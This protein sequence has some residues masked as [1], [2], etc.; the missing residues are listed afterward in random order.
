MPILRFFGGV[1]VIFYFTLAY[2]QAHAQSPPLQRQTST[3]A[4]YSD[5]E[6]TTP[7]GIRLGFSLP[8]CE[9]QSKPDLH[10]SN[11]QGFRVDLIGTWNLILAYETFAVQFSDPFIQKLVY[12][13][14]ALGYRFDLGSW[15]TRLLKTEHIPYLTTFY[16]SFFP[17]WAGELPGAVLAT[18]HTIETKSYRYTSYLATR[19]RIELGWKMTD[20]WDIFIYGFSSKLGPFTVQRSDHLEPGRLTIKIVFLGLRYGF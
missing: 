10:P 14:L 11:C 8:F 12:Q 17:V 2:N 7:L 5:P 16:F 1:L 15:I 19:E 13:S 20:A 18:T 3:P 9:I 6:T 4:S